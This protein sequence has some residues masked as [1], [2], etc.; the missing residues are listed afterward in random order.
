M[1]YTK[2]ELEAM[3]TGMRQA[4]SA[5]YA[6]A[7]KIGC[8]PFIEF[9]GLMNE[10]IQMCSNAL[11]QGQDFTE[12]SIHGGGQ[13]LPMQAHHRAY[14]DEKLQCIY[15]YSLQALTVADATREV[16]DAD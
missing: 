1:T 7:F 10:Y 12:T 2:E 16:V 13:P 6:M 4:S 11:A 9:T 15:G 3:L 8:H 5:F 14:L